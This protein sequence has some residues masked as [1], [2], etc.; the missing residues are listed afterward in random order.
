[1]KA[2]TLDRAYREI[3]HSQTATGLRRFLRAVAAQQA[4]AGPRRWATIVRPRIRAHPIFRL[5]LESPLAAHLY[6]GG[7][8][9]A[10]EGRLVAL[11]RENG[12]P[13]ECSV[14]GWELFACE[15]DLGLAQSVRERAVYPSG[16]RLGSQRVIALGRLADF[17]SASALTRDAAR[18]YALLRQGDTLCIP[19]A[20]CG[21]IDAA[22]LE[23]LGCPLPHDPV[24][25][26]ASF[27][28]RF[29][30]AAFDL[31]VYRHT[32]YVAITKR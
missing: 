7:F 16:R 15:L 14:V 27:Q 6:A 25:M 30:E 2:A 23:I 10:G 28:R 32:A 12:R 9:A 11:L 3:A 8:D 19:V 18:R 22:Y 20:V 17:L 5:L 21:R 24:A 26:V 31:D 1:M 4:G 29:A 13:F